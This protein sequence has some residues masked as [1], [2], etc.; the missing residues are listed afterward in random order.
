MTTRAKN[1]KSPSSIFLTNIWF[2]FFNNNI[3]NKLYEKIIIKI[4]KKFFNLIIS[5]NNYIKVFIFG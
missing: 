3:N 4:N 1:I 2:M 5:A